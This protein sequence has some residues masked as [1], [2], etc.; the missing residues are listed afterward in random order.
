MSALRPK[1][2]IADSAGIGADQDRCGIIKEWRHCHGC[3]E[4]AR[5]ERVAALS[6]APS[7]FVFIF[8]DWR[9]AVAAIQKSG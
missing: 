4:F 7:I 3:R 2:D 1:A 9:P 6:V 5:R 8:V